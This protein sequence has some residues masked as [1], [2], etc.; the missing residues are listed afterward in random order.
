MIQFHLT[1]CSLGLLFASW[2]GPLSRDS[3]TQPPSKS[4]R[5]RF[6]SARDVTRLLGSIETAALCCSISTYAGSARRRGAAGAGGGC[7]PV[8][9]GGTR[10]PPPGA[11]GCAPV[12]PTVPAGR[13]G[14]PRVLG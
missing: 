4:C 8:L 5:P 14:R 6:S 12:H 7:R 10:S 9:S 13:G 3:R 2:Y 1:D 11:A